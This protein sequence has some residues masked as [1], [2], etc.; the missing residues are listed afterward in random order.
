[1]N[2]GELL[3]TLFQFEETLQDLELHILLVSWNDCKSIARPNLVVQKLLTQVALTDSKIF[4]ISK[5]FQ[6]S[7]I[8]I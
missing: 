4:R 7:E 6:P 2:I 8:T 3:S 1:M 5:Q